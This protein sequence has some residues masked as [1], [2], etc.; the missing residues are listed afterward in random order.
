VLKARGEAEVQM[1]Q[2]PPNNPRAAVRKV[3]VPG[4]A[5]VRPGHAAAQ[6]AGALPATCREGRASALPAALKAL[7]SRARPAEPRGGPRRRPFPGGGLKAGA[8]L[9]KGI[10]SEEAPTG[11]RSSPGKGAQPSKGLRGVPPVLTARRAP[12][13]AARGRPAV[14]MGIPAGAALPRDRASQQSR[15]RRAGL[16]L[17]A[18]TAPAA[19]PGGRE[20][21]SQRDAGGI[22]GMS[23]ARPQPGAAA[24]K[25]L[26]KGQI[27]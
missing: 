26:K 24:D 22:D 6:P 8:P 23:R 21:S 17:P 7:S 10:G 2:Q 4:T 3:G 27:L 15:G 12:T 25:A 18:C 9:I 5:R 1:G 16:Q 14:T 20:G 19:P 13:R 11:T